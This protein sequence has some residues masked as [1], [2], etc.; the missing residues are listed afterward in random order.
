MSTHYSEIENLLQSAGLLEIKT[1]VFTFTLDLSFRHERAYAAKLILNVRHPQ[2]DIDE[3]IIKRII[4][5]GD[6]VL[7]AGAHIGF[8]A[9]QMFEAGASS[10]VA[11]EPVPSIYNRLRKL[12]DSEFHAVNMAIDSKSGTRKLILSAS[13]NQG[14]TLEEAMTAI[15][16]SVFGFC[17]ENIDVTLTTI[18]ELGLR[19]GDFD[20]WKL[21]IEGSETS[22]LL[23]GIETMARHPPRIIFAELYDQ[24][25]DEFLRLATQTHQYAYRAFIDRNNY[26]LVLADP[27]TPSSEAFFSTSPMFVFS[28][29]A[30]ER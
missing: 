27:D 25:R 11:V 7:D 30:L 8:T 4:K 23:G 17:P 1:G 16:P 6:R 9:W 19:F 14:A 20:V 21:D 2:C 3:L 13:H 26:G 5:K 22:A 29:E 28:R 15:F 12:R 24:F 18:D 10:V